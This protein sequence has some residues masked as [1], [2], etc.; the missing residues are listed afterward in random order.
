MNK[1]AV[2]LLWEVFCL[3]KSGK[4]LFRCEAGIVLLLAGQGG[5]F[6]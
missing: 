3:G 5:G 6:S 2:V 1:I 4:N